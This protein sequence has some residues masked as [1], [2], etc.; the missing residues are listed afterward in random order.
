MGFHGR[1]LGTLSSNRCKGITK[2]DMP[3]FDWPAAMQPD[4]KYPLEENVAYNQAQDQASLADVRAKITQWKE[5]KG[6]EVVAVIIE[7]IQN[8]GGDNYFSPEFGRALRTLT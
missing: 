3:M 8:E 1:L 2:V 5:E 4:Y 6:S 7:P